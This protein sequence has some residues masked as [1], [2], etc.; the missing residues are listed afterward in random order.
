MHDALIDGSSLKRDRVEGPDA[1]RLAELD[2]LV[3]SGVPA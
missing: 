2:S 1:A 3:G